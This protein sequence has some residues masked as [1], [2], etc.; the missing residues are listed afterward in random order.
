MIPEK[1]VAFIQG[2]A[3]IKAGTRNEELRPAH[4]Y[5]VGAMVSPDRETVTIFVPESRSEKILDNLKSNGRIT[6]AFSRGT[7]ESYQLKGAF[8][9]V[10]PADEAVE[11]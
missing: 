9:S 3:F 11:A 5:C 7:H 10:R 4:A 6:V 1:V 8:V 2:P